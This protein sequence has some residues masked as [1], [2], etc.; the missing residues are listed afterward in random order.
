M[1]KKTIYG[2]V[3]GGSP[4]WYDVVGICEDGVVLAGHICSTHEFGKYDIGVTSDR[5]HALYAKHCPDGFQVVW[6]DH[7]LIHDGLKEAFRLNA[8]LPLA[9]EPEVAP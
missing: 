7:P 6:V 8:L 2:F 1:A 5:K 4:G 3:N 9:S